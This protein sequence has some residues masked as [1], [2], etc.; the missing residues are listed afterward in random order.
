MFPGPPVIPKRAGHL[1]QNSFDLLL[2]N[3]VYPEIILIKP[4]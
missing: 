1:A 4:D 2:N 3:K